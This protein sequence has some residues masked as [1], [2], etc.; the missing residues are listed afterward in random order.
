MI[1]NNP[2]LMLHL[3]LYFAAAV[4]HFSTRGDMGIGII[5]FV[6]LSLGH[7][8]DYNLM[9]FPFQPQK[10]KTDVLSYRLAKRL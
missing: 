3:G 9:Y 10:M 5:L 8:I 7:I 2:P 1:D 4:L 6:S